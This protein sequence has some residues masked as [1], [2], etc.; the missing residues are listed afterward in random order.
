[1]F[2]IAYVCSVDKLKQLQMKKFI[3]NTDDLNAY[4]YRILTSGIQVERFLK[5]P[6]A[7]YDHTRSWGGNINRLPI[8]NWENLEKGTKQMTAELRMDEVTDMDKAVKAKVDSGTLRT[9]SIGIHILEWSD[10]PKLLVQGQTRPTVTKCILLEASVTD[11]PANGNCIKLS[12]GDKTVI[13]NNEEDY[14]EALDSIL[15]TIKLNQEM[16]LGL[17]SLTKYLGLEDTANEADVLAHISTLQNSNATLSAKVT[18]L[19]E[20]L[21]VVE[22]ES[23]ENK[24]KDLVQLAIEKKKITESQ[25]GT[26]ESLAMNDYD[27]AKAAL[28]NMKGFTSLSSQID[29]PDESTANLDDKAKYEK[30]WKEGKLSLWEQQN[31]EEFKRCQSAFFSTK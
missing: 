2:S 23:T 5:N 25:R 12:Y 11:I 15:P 20:K 28:A 26:W 1:M 24:A 30:N 4:G 13:L 16:N 10:D 19:E 6:V 7:L 21:K 22:Q 8:G 27:N 18:E 9:T 17:K 14:L 31:P 29:E 3:L